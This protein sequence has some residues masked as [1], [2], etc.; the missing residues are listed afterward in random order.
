[1]SLDLFMFASNFGMSI[2]K[3]GAMLVRS[4]RH[5][6]TNGMFVPQSVRVMAAGRQPPICSDFG[7]HQDSASAHLV[8]SSIICPKA[9]VS[10]VQA[11]SPPLQAE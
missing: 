1:M 8:R 11:L 5:V 9:V 10:S 6:N 7:L 2:R 4:V 3:D